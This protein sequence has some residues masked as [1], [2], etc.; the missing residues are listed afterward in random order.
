MLVE[1]CISYSEIRIGLLHFV[2][3]PLDRPEKTVQVFMHFPLHKKAK[4]HVVALYVDIPL[5]EF[6]V[7]FKSQS[8]HS[9]LYIT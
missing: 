5:W 3:C 4:P 1:V 6:I 7:V 2:K 9:T 8:G